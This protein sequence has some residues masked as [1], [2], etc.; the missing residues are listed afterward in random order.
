MSLFLLADYLGRYQYLKWIE[1][2][3]ERNEDMHGKYYSGQMVGSANIRK[4][5]TNN[6]IRDIQREKICLDVEPSLRG[7]GNY[8][9]RFL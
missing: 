9:Y 2:F 3:P 6:S 4:E 7:T 8:V 1:K 5:N